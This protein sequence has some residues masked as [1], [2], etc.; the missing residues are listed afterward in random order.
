MHT[1]I[2]CARCGTSPT[3][4]V[5]YNDGGH[6]LLCQEC[7]GMDLNKDHRVP[8]EVEMAVYGI[9]TAGMPVSGLL[10]EV[11]EAVIRDEHGREHGRFHAA[12]EILAGIE[13]LNTREM[14]DWKV[15]AIRTVGNPRAD[16]CCKFLCDEQG[17]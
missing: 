15:V 6:I 5:R 4:D 8:S 9:G 14:G 3:F 16:L 17:E 1:R 7:E 12:A 10:L 13:K 11:T 2:P